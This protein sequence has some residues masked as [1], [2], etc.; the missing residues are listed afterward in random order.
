MAAG[1]SITAAVA[2]HVEFGMAVAVTECGTD[3]IAAAA[4][5]AE[6]GITGTTGIPATIAAHAAV[7]QQQQH[8]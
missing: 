1:V 7:Q 3:G 8:R 4:M 2:T 5:A 6:H